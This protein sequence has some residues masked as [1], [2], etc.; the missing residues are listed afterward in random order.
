M[1]A[2]VNAF[3][4]CEGPGFCPRYQREMHGRLRQICRGENID[5]GQAALYRDSWVAEAK[6][7][8]APRPAPVL[9][10]PHRG[11]EALVDAEGNPRLRECPS[12][13]GHVKLKLFACCHPARVVSAEQADEIVATDCAACM[14]QP[15]DLAQARRI[16]LKNHLCP[17][18]VLVMT[19]AI[20]GL[21]RA[22]PG[23]F[24]VSVD[25]TCQAIFEHN[26]DV[27]AIAE[28]AELV[29]MHYPL[30]HQ[31]NQRAVH[32]LEGYCDF[33]GG[34]LGV[35]VPCLVNRPLVY[36]SRQEKSWVSQVQEI[37]GRPTA[38]WVLNA[39]YKTDYTTKHWPHYQE[40]VDR[41]LGRVLFVQVGRTEHCHRPLR[42]VLDLIGK[43]DDRQLIRLVANSQG[44]VCGTTFLMHLAA[45]LEKPA[46]VLA[47]GREPRAWNQYPLSTVLGSVGAL[48][49]CRQHACWRSRT[50]A[51][52]D[53][54]DGDKSLCE[55]PVYTDPPAARC[56]ALIS[57]EQAAAAVLA[58]QP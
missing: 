55:A 41:L 24:A 27:V 54:A 5:A 12:C 35:K 8:T 57:A 3:C 46:V 21:V 16:V 14:Y 4:E 23:K 50:V 7:G 28:G 6:N 10:C 49:C 29:E 56:M 31:S 34:A 51:L 30:V 11:A 43:T 20:H 15:R 58:Y 53:G 17:G 42:G 22:H 38:Y 9:T 25:S 1:T 18:D 26:P 44:V 39:G 13:G 40:I 52:G 2:G 36:L 33:L 19:A 45:A 48:P 37:T 47:G 32:F